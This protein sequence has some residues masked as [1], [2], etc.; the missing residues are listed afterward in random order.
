MLKQKKKVWHEAMLPDVDKHVEKKMADLSGTFNSV[1]EARLGELEKLINEKEKAAPTRNQF[2]VYSKREVRIG[3]S[4][5][6]KSESSS[7]VKQDV[8]ND[9][10]SEDEITIN[11]PESEYTKKE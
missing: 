5:T 1:L 4:G 8:P 6:L 10:K 9:V 3:A 7:I 2:P 11:V